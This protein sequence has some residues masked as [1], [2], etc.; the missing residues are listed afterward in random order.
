MNENIIH[1]EYKEMFSKEYTGNYL[2]IIYDKNKNTF[3]KIYLY[4][5][6]YSTINIEKSE[7]IVHKWETED[8]AKE[9]SYLNRNYQIICLNGIE[10]DKTLENNIIM[11]NMNYVNKLNI[12]NENLKI[13]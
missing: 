11:E 4:N 1:L 7:K 13:W 5:Y 12:K 10:N 8:Q 9:G 2:K 3:N 6:K